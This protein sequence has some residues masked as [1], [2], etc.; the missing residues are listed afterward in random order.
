MDQIKNKLLILAVF[1]FSGISALIYQIIWIRLMGQIFGNSTYAISAVLAAFMSG[2]ALGSWL[3]GEIVQRKKNLIKIYAFL[4]IGIALSAV[5]STFAMLNLDIFYKYI[6][7]GI[8]YSSLLIILV[9]FVFGFVLVLIPTI[10]LGATLPTISQYLIRKKEEIGKK[11]SL[12]YALNT[13]GGLIG[14]VLVSFYL[15]ERI[16]LPGSLTFAVINN[17]VLGLL[18]F[19]VYRKNSIDENIT[20]IELKSEKKIEKPSF[21]KEQML[22]LA[23][24]FITGFFSFA[25]EILWTRALVFYNG[26][27]TYSF[28]LVLIIFLTGIASGSF[29]IQFFADKIKNKW[30]SIIFIA[31]LTFLFS[32]FSIYL[33]HHVF[34]LQFF[35]PENSNWLLYLFKNMLKTFI[36]IFLPTLGLGMIFPLVNVLYIKNIKQVSKHIGNLYAINTIGS[37]VGSVFTSFVLIPLTGISRSI[38]IVSAVLLVWLCVLFFYKVNKNK[39][40]YIIGTTVICSAFIVYSLVARFNYFQS[41]DEGDIRQVKFYNEGVSATCKVYETNDQSLKMTVNGVLMGGDFDKAL[42]KQKILADLPLVLNADATDIF[43]V[44]LGTGI[45]L[46]EF[47]KFEKKLNIDCAEISRSVVLGSKFFQPDATD[48]FE[49]SNVNL[50]IEDGL[51]YLKM[52]NKSYD[53]ISSDTMLK[54]GSA[55]NSIMYSRDYYK[56]VSEHLKPS[57]IFIQW[58][59]LYLNPDIYNIILN[60]V[61]DSF[62]HTSLW[63]VGDEA[64]LHISTNEPFEIDYQR[65]RSNYFDTN[66]KSQF[67]DIDFTS[68]ESILS[69]LIEEKLELPQSPQKTINSVLY[70]VVEFQVPRNLASYKNVFVNLSQF[71]KLKEMADTDHTFYRGISE[72]DLSVIE[73]FNTSY[74]H[75]IRG[76]LYF[77]QGNSKKAKTEF[78]EALLI[79]PNDSNVHHFLGI[80]DMYSDRNKKARAMLECGVLLFEKRE[81][82]LALEY[83]H[84]SLEYNYN[85]LVILNYMSLSYSNKKDFK[86]AI[87]Y[88]EQLVESAPNNYLFVYNLG[89]FYEQ[90]GY[91]QKALDNYTLSFK[92]NP[93]NLNIKQDIQRL[94]Q[95]LN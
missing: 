62:K 35:H 43:V 66:L 38:L 74:R 27:S 5:L 67:N 90:G 31:A 18:I 42:R 63:Y 26:N 65:I 40:L 61:H 17:L 49:N 39:L 41:Y 2:L 72:T 92:L 79:N 77:Y 4:E 50:V 48:F 13:F 52:T 81:F 33:L 53:I 6:I 68:P 12:L 56:L 82:D 75:V 23:T 14:I 95:K 32:A 73:I 37:I 51:N 8:G 60:T 47:L 83:F 16:G 64:M 29:V 87:I 28:S 20:A 1:L 93:K 57:G 84:K 45:T 58:I 46:A 15:I 69:I 25:L 88:A 59:P 44:G 22:L 80:S 24:A 94:Q 76:L 30:N 70:P 78:V 36:V 11:Y 34:P 21:E 9:R 19:F 10:L 3:A 86:N 71:L 85:K 7:S 55:G 54:K 91:L 89:Y